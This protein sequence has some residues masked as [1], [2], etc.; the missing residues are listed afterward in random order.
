MQ[1]HFNAPPLH[2]PFILRGTR[3]VLPGK[4]FGPD[5]EVRLPPGL[6]GGLACCFLSVKLT[7]GPDILFYDM[8]VPNNKMPERGRL[9][10]R[11]RTRFEFW[12]VCYAIR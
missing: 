9:L 4:A 6:T 7:S 2:D 10:S 12:R 3:A 5:W 11:Q 1:K 8:A